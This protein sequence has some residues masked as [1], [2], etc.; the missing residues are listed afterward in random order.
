MRQFFKYNICLIIIVLVSVALTGYGFILYEKGYTMPEEGGAIALSVL[1]LREG[2]FPWNMEVRYDMEGIP[3]G[4]DGTAV[5]DGMATEPEGEAGDGGNGDVVPAL[6][7]NEAG[8]EEGDGS[9]GEEK[10]GTEGSEG[11]ADGDAAGIEGSEAGVDGG[12]DGTG[13]SEGGTEG[14][15]SEN[16]SVSGNS[17]EISGNEAEPGTVSA[18]EPEDL[19]PPEFIEVG[20]EYFADA[21]FIGDSRMD[22]LALYKPINGA[23]YYTK[24]S[25]S[26]YNLMKDKIR[27]DGRS[28]TIREW[29]GEYQFR[30]IYISVGLNNAGIRNIDTFI[31][32]YREVVAEIRTLQPNALIFV[33]GTMHVTGKLSQSSKDFNNNYINERNAALKEFAMEEKLIYIDVNEV[34][35]NEEG[36]LPDAMT[37]DG[38]HMY[39]RYYEPWRDYYFTHGIWLEPLV[40]QNEE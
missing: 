9:S 6:S 24:T 28:R 32:R 13:G 40:E 19:W 7:E 20:E 16:E 5:E 36:N 23:T 33:E 30:K 27:I 29:L 1:S 8:P 2:V 21:L 35:D 10:P 3:M 12:A 22:G 31:Q 15:P 4:E 11:G 25:M 17:G 14:S 38:V 37:N 18:N 39:A 26:I 34:Y